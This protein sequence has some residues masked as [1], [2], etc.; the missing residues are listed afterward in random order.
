MYRPRHSVV[1]RRPGSIYSLCNCGDDCEDCGSSRSSA[2]DCTAS[3]S[4]G[5]ISGGSSGG[6]ISV[7]SG[8][9]ASG[10]L[11]AAAGIALFC[12][13]YQSTPSILVRACPSD[14]AAYPESEIMPLA[15]LT[16][17]APSPLPMR[18]PRFRPR[19]HRTASPPSWSTPSS[20][21]SAL[22][23]S[24]QP[25]PT[26][27]LA[28]SCRATT[29]MRRRRSCPFSAAPSNAAPTSRSRSAPGLNRPQVKGP[30]PQSACPQ[31]SAPP[32]CR[33][34]ARAPRSLTTS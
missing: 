15:P 26:R 34:L 13:L 20:P 29:R 24:S 32:S 18:R 21:A 1:P 9:G 30:R 28:E 17:V 5:S 2:S 10:G 3:A 12:A 25:S 7:E 11:S 6:S 22:Q 16:T 27:R 33:A 23:S 8:S 19:L 14:S 31:L 4:G